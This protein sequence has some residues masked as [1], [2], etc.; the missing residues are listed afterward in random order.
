VLAD[1]APVRAERALLLLP[2][3]VW[4]MKLV[5]TGSGRSGTGWCAATLNSAGV[6][7]GHENVFTP[8]A[9]K[10]NAYIEWAGY[11][12]DCSWLAVPRLPLFNVRAALVVRNPLDV[13]ASMWHIHFG[14]PGYENQFSAVA[15]DAGM[16]P[17]LSG[18]LRFWVEWNTR[19]LPHVE[20]VFTLDQLVDNPM[21]L[22]RWAGAKREP[23][24][25]GVVNDR[26][27][28]KHG[29]RPE[30]NWDCFTD[31]V[32][33]DQAQQLWESLKVAA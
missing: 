5:V 20:A 29:A 19:A 12:A 16:T 4:A 33:V 26:P 15:A 2:Q 13:V 8:K 11:R 23:K 30:L 6:F 24:P 27:E 18:W 25:V 17:N 32:A 1:R 9:T 14:K 28:W 10:P 3:G 31:R 21:T 22:T 7:S